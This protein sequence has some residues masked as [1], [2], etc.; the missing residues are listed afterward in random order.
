MLNIF[1]GKSRVIFG[2][3][4]IALYCCATFGWAGLGEGARAQS[5]ATAPPSQNVPNA[6]SVSSIVTAYAKGQDEKDMVTKEIKLD[7]DKKARLGAKKAAQEAKQADV[8]HK[9]RLFNDAPAQVAM[10]A[11]L[12][13][14]KATCEGRVLY[15]ADIGRC[16]AAHA[17]IDPRSNR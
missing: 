11:D 17:S 5:A 13:N 7:E 8:D 12:A 3:T 10:R 9:A 16:D 15:G 2:L 6:I 14:Y 4:R 1:S